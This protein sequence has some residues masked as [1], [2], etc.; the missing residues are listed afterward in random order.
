MRNDGDLSEEVLREMQHDL[1]LEEALLER[2]S[3]AVDGHLDELPP[4]EGAEPPAGAEVARA[5]PAGAADAGANAEAPV[6]EAATVDDAEVSAL[7]LDEQTAEGAAVGRTARRP[8][9]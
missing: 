7:L 5:G 9:E 2:R 4:G 3:L 8:A 1:D 6:D